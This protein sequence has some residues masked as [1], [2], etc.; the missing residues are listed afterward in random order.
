MTERS[1][2]NFESKCTSAVAASYTRELSNNDCK[3]AAA[4]E[5]CMYRTALRDCQADP[6]VASPTPPLACTVF[7]SRTAVQQRTGS[8]VMYRVPVV[9]SYRHSTMGLV[10]SGGR[11]GAKK[12]RAA[13]R[14]CAHF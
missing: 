7:L 5:G 11:W 12:S 9:V 4:G 1:G 2:I 8:A 13:A 14:S 10:V 3:P 6:E